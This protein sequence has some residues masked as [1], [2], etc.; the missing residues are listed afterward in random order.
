MKTRQCIVR[1]TRQTFKIVSESSLRGRLMYDVNASEKIFPSAT[2]TP[3][4]YQD[5]PRHQ[6]YLGYP[7][8]PWERETIL[9]LLAYQD[10]GVLYPHSNGSGTLQAA[11]VTILCQYCFFWPGK[12]STLRIRTSHVRT[13][14][15]V[16]PSCSSW[17]PGLT[18]TSS[19][20]ARPAMATISPQCRRRQI[21]R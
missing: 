21:F 14:T 18:T 12:G 2:L 8:Y 3:S 7:Q 1:W 10:T 20:A 15:R 6:Q 17:S 5:R 4:C 16:W 13:V 11:I 19:T 9:F